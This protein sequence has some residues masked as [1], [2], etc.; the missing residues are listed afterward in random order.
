VEVVLCDLDAGREELLRE[1]A[2]LGP[3]V[4]D[5]LLRLRDRRLEIRAVDAQPEGLLALETLLEA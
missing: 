2:D 4:E 1:A 3:L 5:L